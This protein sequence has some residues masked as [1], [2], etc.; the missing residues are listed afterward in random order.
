MVLCN[1]DISLTYII[2]ICNRNLSWVYIILSCPCE[3]SPWHIL[4]C[5]LSL[6][7][8]IYICHVLHLVEGWRH[9]PWYILMTYQWHNNNGFMTYVNDI[10]PWH[11]TMTICH[12]ISPWHITITYLHDIS[13][14]CIT[15]TYH[16]DIYTWH[17]SRH[18]IS[19][20]DIPAHHDIYDLAHT[21]TISSNIHMSLRCRRVTY[22]MRYVMVG[23]VSWVYVM[24]ICHDVIVYV[25]VICHWAFFTKCSPWH[26]RIC[27]GALYVMVTP[28]HD[29]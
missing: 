29:I 3:I 14:W 22:V 13:P 8:V 19:H 7:Y 11:I 26:I 2:D 28:L 21:P 1:D 23:G 27:H 17:M 24:V 4:V 12:D 6:R 5:F 18:D 15:M 25:M 20:H 9:R 10:S 16:H